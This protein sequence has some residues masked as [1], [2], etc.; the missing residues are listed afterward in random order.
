LALTPAVAR[1]SSRSTPLGTNGLVGVACGQT[2]TLT[3]ILANETEPP[4]HIINLRDQWYHFDIDNAELGRQLSLDRDLPCV[5]AGGDTCPRTTSMETL[6]LRGYI[7]TRAERVQTISEQ[8]PCVACHALLRLSLP[9][10]LAVTSLACDNIVRDW[11]K[12]NMPETPCAKGFA[13]VNYL[14]VPADA[15]GGDAVAASVTRAG[16]RWRAALKVG[17]LGYGR[18]R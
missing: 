17:W 4:L 6:G 18:Q 14:C 12:C 16:A 7:A 10:V 5:N 3:G 11:S 13:C 8:R 1:R 15:G 2:Y 9:L